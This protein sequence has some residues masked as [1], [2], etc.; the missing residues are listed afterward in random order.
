MS[1]YERACRLSIYLSNADIEHHK[2]LSAQIL[3]RAHHAGLR[4][5]TTLHGVEGFGHSGRIHDAAKWTIVNRGPLTVHLV[6]TPERIRA[7][8][9]QLDDL[10]G[11]CLIVCDEVQVRADDS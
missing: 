11:K 9:P 2:P 7:F 8:L 3:H 6:D 10:A 4:G 1:H 5:A